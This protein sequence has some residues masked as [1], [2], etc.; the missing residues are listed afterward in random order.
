M[1]IV[2]LSNWCWIYMSN[3]YYIPVVLRC[4]WVNGIS[5]VPLV[6]CSTSSFSLW[7]LSDSILSSK[8][9]LLTQIK[10]YLSIFKFFESCFKITLDTDV[11]LL[12]CLARY[13]WIYEK[14]ALSL[15]DSIYFLDEH[16]SQFFLQVDTML[17]CTFV[18]ETIYT[19]LQKYTQFCLFM[20]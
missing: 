9:S 11:H 4:F 12:I 13:C 16:I 3:L 7:T 17:D 19:A 1:G 15:C 10:T 6:V 18:K 20:M 5:S 2:S 14:I 8:C